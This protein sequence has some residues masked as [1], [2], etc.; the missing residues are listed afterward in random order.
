MQ[1]PA[2]LGLLAATCSYFLGSIP[3]GYLIGRARGMDIREHG[4]GNIGATNVLRV[5]GKKWGY[6]VF[7]LDALKGLLAVRLAFAFASAAAANSAP[8]DFVGIVGGLA[9]I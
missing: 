2:W 1:N 6:F 4:S 7:T 9:C 3:T 5:V 8:P